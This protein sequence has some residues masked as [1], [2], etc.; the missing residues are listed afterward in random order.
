MTE[1]DRLTSILTMSRRGRSAYT[2]SPTLDYSS[3]AQ[4]K[5]AELTPEY[6][7]ISTTYDDS[8]YGGAYDVKG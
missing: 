3:H 5:V 4:R 2:S 6:S 7:D 8:P 1:I